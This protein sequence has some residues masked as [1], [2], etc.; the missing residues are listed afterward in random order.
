MIDSGVLRCVCASVCVWAGGGVMMGEGMRL[1]EGL[2]TCLYPHFWSFSFPQRCAVNG[3]W[4]S[5]GT[6]S[7]L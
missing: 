1:E 4:L 6:N 7:E 2:E 3:S 5:L